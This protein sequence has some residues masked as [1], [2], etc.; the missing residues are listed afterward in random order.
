QLSAERTAL[1]IRQGS[2]V[3][4]RQHR[5]AI[6]S[7]RELLE[8]GEQRRIIPP[9]PLVRLAITLD[10]TL[11]PRQLDR[12][13]AVRGGE[14]FDAHEPILDTRVLLG[15]AVCSPPPALHAPESMQQEEATDRMGA[16]SPAS[17]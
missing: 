7:R 14:P 13:I 15:V 3:K 11:C 2:L 8:A 4:P 6:R 9:A 17:R 10:K 12:Q 1:L 5:G 16:D